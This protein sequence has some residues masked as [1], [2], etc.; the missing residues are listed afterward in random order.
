VKS[1]S[2]V[3]HITKE[4]NKR[5]FFLRECRRAHL[6]D[7]VG[8]TC[9]KTKTRPLVEY[10]API[11][12][13]LPSYYEAEIESIERRSL[14]ILGLPSDYLPSLSQRRN[15]VTL[16]EFKRIMDEDTH[17]CSD[18]NPKHINHNYHLRSNK[19]KVSIFSGTERH[20][21]RSSFIPTA[22]SLF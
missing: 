13:G 2:H 16:Q 8:I 4:A 21:H 3:E 18:L 17:P 14:K 22:A 20:V 15:N 12:G 19:K 1:N 7:E 6:P 5:L 10:G 11:W 9:Y